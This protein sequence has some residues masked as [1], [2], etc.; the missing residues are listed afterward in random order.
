MRRFHT[1]LTPCALGFGEAHRSPA[2][3]QGLAR[4]LVV[5]V[6]SMLMKTIVPSKSHSPLL[7][8]NLGLTHYSCTVGPP[9]LLLCSIGT[10]QTRCN[11][12]GFFVF[13][14]SIL[15]FLPFFRKP[16]HILVEHEKSCPHD[17][18]GLLVLYS[19]LRFLSK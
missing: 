12:F 19:F 17:S 9:S 7:G 1:V 3:A 4:S 8:P 11:Y 10:S 13:L 18:H 5:F 16:N 14:W 15:F 2:P 6:S